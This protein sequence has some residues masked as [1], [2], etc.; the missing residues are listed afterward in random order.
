MFPGIKKKNDFLNFLSCR[1]EVMGINVGNSCILVEIKRSG[2]LLPH[3]HQLSVCH[4]ESHKPLQ[5]PA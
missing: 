4:W 2:L 1:M 3:P 5:T